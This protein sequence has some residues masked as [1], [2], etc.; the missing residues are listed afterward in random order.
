MFLAEVLLHPVA[1]VGAEQ[2]DPAGPADSLRVRELRK[3]GLPMASHRVA[4]QLHLRQDEA[5]AAGLTVL[6]DQQVTT[7]QVDATVDG[8]L[9][10]SGDLMLGLNVLVNVHKIFLLLT[11]GGTGEAGLP[12]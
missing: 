4:E 7:W 5:G 11:T 1:V 6:L 12:L 10:V 9:V 3:F 2:T 8:S